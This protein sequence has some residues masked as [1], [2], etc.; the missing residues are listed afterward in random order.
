[1]PLPS[2]RRAGAIDEAHAARAQ[3]ESEIE[4]MSDMARTQVYVALRKLRESEH[5]L[6]LFQT[7]LLPVARDQVDAAQAGF[8]A[9]QTSFTAVVEAE[10]NLRSVELD[11]RMAQAQA[12]R[13]QAELDRALGRT[14]GID[15]E[16][17]K[18]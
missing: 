3:Y 12:D 10:K 17:S 9:S 1:V 16:G 5:V 13:R 7:R 15:V 8:T 14:P 18:R 6:G 4:R 2:E 11:Y